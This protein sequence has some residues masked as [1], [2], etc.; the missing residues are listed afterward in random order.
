MQDADTRQ[1]LYSL[2]VLQFLVDEMQGSFQDLPSPPPAR[3]A[4]GSKSPSPNR[5]LGRSCGPLLSPGNSRAQTGHL[6]ASA[7]S[8]M[9]G[10]PQRHCRSSSSS[11]SKRIPILPKAEGHDSELGGADRA[12]ALHVPVSA[13]TSSSQSFASPSA[14][15]ALSLTPSSAANRSPLVSA[16]EPSLASLHPQSSFKF[17]RKE[18]SSAFK[19]LTGQIRAVRQSPGHFHDENRPAGV[20]GALPHD[21][22]D[23]LP[24]GFQPTGDLNEDVKQLERLDCD[25]SSD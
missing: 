20:L 10:S 1:L 18:S 14:H 13:P 22:D 6:P 2:G 15:R 16:S 8:S 12:G 17:N 9:S 7:L 3:T 24:A 4:L 25:V 5:V 11:P 19:Q 21:I 23:Q